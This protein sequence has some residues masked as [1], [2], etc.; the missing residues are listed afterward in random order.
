[1]AVKFSN[2]FSTSLAVA[3]SSTATTLEL[4][5]VTGLPTLG[6]GD[7]TYLT[8]DTDTVSPTIEVVKVTAV[9]TGTNEITVTRGQDNTTASAFDAGT[10]VELRLTS[11][12]LNDVSDEASVTLWADIQNKPDSVITLAGDASGSATMTDLGSAT[13]T[14]TIADDSHNHVISNVDGL[15][16]AL[17][18]KQDAST[19]LTT[20]N[21]STTLDGRYYTETEIGAFFSGSSAI[22]GYNKTNWDT[23]YG[24]GDHSV[25]GYLTGNQTITLTGDVSGSGTTSIAVTI[26]DDSHNHVISNV[27]GL[28]TALDAKQDTSTALTTSTSFGGDVSGTYNAI[29]ITDDS[30][31][32]VIS[33]VDGLQTALDGKVD[34]AGDTM[35]GSLTVTGTVTADGLTVDGTGDLGTIG[36][37]AFNQA[38]ALGFQGDRA[39]FGYSSSQNTLIQSGA[40]KGV[41][42]EVNNDTLD[43]GT[44][45]A[46]FSSNGDISFYE[47]TGS[48]A[49]LFWDASDS[50]LGVGTTSPDYTFHAYHPT[51]NVVARFESG[52]AEV[53][54]DLH[55]S[56]SGT[57]G[58][59]LGHTS[60]ELFKVAD[61]SVDVRMSLNNNG[62]LDT[63]AG[64]SV[65]GT[66][67]IDSSREGSFAT[68]ATF[69]GIDSA[70]NVQPSANNTVVSGYGLIG[71]R[72]TYYITNSG[73]VIQIGNGSIHNNNPTATFSTS[74]V[75]L[76]SGRSL[77]ID[78][79]TVLTSARAATNLVSVSLDAVDGNGYG[80]WD[81][82]TNYAIWMSSAGNSTYGGRVSGETTSDYNMYFKMQSGTNRGFVFKDEANA[83]FSIN[84]NSGVHSE[85][86]G[87]WQ[88]Y[89]RMEK[90][91]TATSSTTGY[92]SQEI[93][94]R[95][96]GWDTNNSVARNCDWHVRAEA[97]PS[98]YPDQ[99][100]AFYEQVP[101]YGHKKFELHG[102]NSGASYQHPDAA[103]FYGNLQVAQTSDS[104]GGD[105]SV[106]GQAYIT[107]TGGRPIE[108]G[109]V[110]SIITKGSNG[111]WAQG[112]KF[113]GYSGADLGGFGA[114]GN[115]NTMTYFWIGST[116]NGAETFK[117]YPNGQIVVDG[118]TLQQSTDRNGLLEIYS[119]GTSWSGFQITKAS[120]NHWSIMGDDDNLGLYDD[121]AGEWILLYYQ[122]AYASIYYNGA[123]KIRTQSDG[124]RILGNLYI[125]EYIYH[126]GDTNSYL[127]FIAADDVQLVAGGRQMIRMDE[128]TNPDRLYFP[129]GSSYTDSNG[130]A[131]FAGNV[132]AYASDRRLKTNIKPIENALDKVMAIRGVTYDWIDEVKE[133]GFTP[134]RQHDCMG[135][136]AQE[137]EEAGVDQV[138]M[139]APFD[140]IRTKETDWKDVSKSGE[141]YKTVDYD[142]LTALLIE[143]VKEQQTQIE[144][145]QAK[146]KELEN[147]NH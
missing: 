97:T 111:G 31:N 147:G 90:T 49:K 71:N 121:E 91:G 105:L 129:N 99:H 104:T 46:L 98:V 34:L 93:V 59:L 139:P 138:I 21:Y 103:T 127:R 64:Y 57:Y 44:R 94:F 14:V 12:L 17:D 123:E 30:H 92:P 53:W 65:G 50:R 45:A 131:V 19:A 22:T 77:Q 132:T 73:G 6:S 3:A 116:Y 33:N 8:I 32:H 55:D 101:S 15:Q 10:K 112:Y 143:A 4:A 124:A 37:G 140:R 18:A 82:S 13:L 86:P 27:D 7:Y 109:D 142:K 75:N 87:F 62:L 28:Q 42:I 41:V 38:A 58:A 76:A 16:T 130:T 11:I 20:S 85:V 56:D 63:D 54:I 25:E 24:W 2:N 72:G 60:T 125:D 136:I 48:N 40:S 5:S 145:L 70:G 80:F 1:M 119:S 128:G 9:N 47:D 114:L 118:L 115:V 137:L 79:T 51:T 102:R 83:F 68:K 100:L 43:S 52:D 35:T 146:I 78:G 133:L 96:S 39:Y 89:F 61:A 67:A 110:G 84:P 36:N 23:A 134:D 106:V 66:T 135:V 141:E 74:A 126:Q 120:G 117:V 144:A 113:E 88:S 122:N 108:I 95:S 69:G 81:S 107:G 26:A 29:V